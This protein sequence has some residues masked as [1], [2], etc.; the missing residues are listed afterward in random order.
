MDKIATIQNWVI[1]DAIAKGQIPP[2]YRPVDETGNLWLFPAGGQAVRPTKLVHFKV[3]W[4]EAHAEPF[5]VVDF[6]SYYSAT[7]SLSGPNGL[8][9]WEYVNNPAFDPY[10]VS[11]M[12][13]FQGTAYIW[14]GPPALIPWERL[15]KIR[16]WVSHNA[17]FDELVYHRCVALGLI[18]P[19][20]R[21]L[22]WD[23]TADMAAFL[24]RMRGLL[25]SV[26][27][28]L[29]L[30][31]DKSVVQRLK[32]GGDVT[33]EELAQYNFAD[34]WYSAL[35]WCRIALHQWPEKE[36]LLSRQT[37]YLGWKGIWVDDKQLKGDTAALS[38]LMEKLAVTIPWNGGKRSVTSIDEFA[39]QCNREGI[40]APASLDQTDPMTVKWEK[41]YGVTR[42]WLKTIFRYTKCRQ[43]RS[44]FELL[45]ERRRI[46]GTVPFDLLYCKAPH[47][48][49]WQSGKKLR[50]QNLDRDACEG[51]KVRHRLRPPPGHIFIIRDSSQI[52]PRVLNWLAGDFDFLR[53]CQKCS[54]YEAHARVNMGYALDVPMKKGD[55]ANYQLAKAEVLA[56]G[57]Q[58]GPPKF[59]E[60]AHDMCGMN[61]HEFERTASIVVGSGD[62]SS[63]IWFNAKQIDEAEKGHGDRNLM[64]A[65]DRKAIA[66]YPP[67]VEVVAS[68][69]SAA[70]KIRNMW[71]RVQNEMKADEGHDHLVHMPNGTTL[72][73]FD[74][75][76]SE[77]GL[78]A[79]VIQN[80]PD[81][82]Q[83]K[84]FYGGKLTENRVQRMSRAI[85][86]EILVR[87]EEMPVGRVGWHSHDEAI[88]VVPRQH[89]EE[90]LDWSGNAFNTSI[91]WA[92]GLPLASEGMIAEYYDK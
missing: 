18:P 71:Y 3:P 20:F 51:I 84:Y 24:Q 26:R 29:G 78:T 74:V 59:V 91:S 30:S 50:I 6:E 60:M 9:S 32:G 16:Q 54:P 53:A 73:Y 31:V 23:C 47:T 62:S 70:K 45:L 17:S 49:R 80:S 27:D 25:E 7:Y 2:P 58:A 12:A 38:A 64:D 92:P 83:R 72:Y 41:L 82:K 39:K 88:M 52:E 76:D 66:I 34:C 15:A 87:L 68:F 55:P 81:P 1:Q 46:D 77:S 8:S 19:G 86:G 90:M 4:P 42:P 63:T 36:R 48:Q 44:F 75:I 5:V 79:N 10:C 56:L 43:T 11:V 21:P 28:L 33:E 37:R 13:C 14:V 65:I 85:L 89:A 57:Y 61:L 22:H 40:P 69:R 35:L 67:G